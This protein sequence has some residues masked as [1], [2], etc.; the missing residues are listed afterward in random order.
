MP[1]TDRR[2]LRY[3]VPTDGRDHAIGAGQVLIVRP[4]RLAPL[5]SAT[6]VEVFV[7][8]EVPINW[9]AS[10]DTAQQVV[11]VIRTG[12]LVPDGGLWVGSCLDGQ[13]VWHVYRTEAR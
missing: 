3:E 4:W 7:E 1:D 11:V 8:R 6:R 10:D 5:P 13:L 2:V 12:S 9:P